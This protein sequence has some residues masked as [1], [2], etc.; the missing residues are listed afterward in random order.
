MTSLS[1]SRSACSDCSCS[2]DP[3][4]SCRLRRAWTAKTGPKSPGR[5]LHR[6]ISA[7]M[8]SCFRSNMMMYG[9]MLIVDV[10]RDE[11]AG[12]ANRQLG[13]VEEAC[14]IISVEEV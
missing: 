10:D 11:D 14:K 12:H 1:G 6:H 4:R 13:R 9:P 2:H 8:R 7:G 5:P 3:S